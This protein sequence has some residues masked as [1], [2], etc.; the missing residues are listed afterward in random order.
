[1]TLSQVLSYNTFHLI[2]A[3]AHWQA[4]ADQREEVFSG[5]RDDALTL[6]WEG[7]AA[8]A[9]HQRTGTDYNTAMDS[10]GNLRQAATIFT[11]TTSRR[12][13]RSY[14]EVWPIPPSH[15]SRASWI[16]T[17]RFCICIRLRLAVAAGVPAPAT[18]I[19]DRRTH[20][21]M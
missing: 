5:V 13:I 18:I 6:P 19:G 10:A 1:M 20:I 14:M 17:S 9:L 2:D 15:L 4:L 11:L 7:Q 16:E 3:S 12:L 8:D 21:P